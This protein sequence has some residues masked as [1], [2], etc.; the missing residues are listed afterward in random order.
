MYNENIFNDHVYVQ[1]L[2][3]HISNLIIK[4]RFF[5][6]FCDFRDINLSEKCERQL[7]YRTYF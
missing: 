1:I 3:Y 6:V 4:S 7:L 5:G 2:I